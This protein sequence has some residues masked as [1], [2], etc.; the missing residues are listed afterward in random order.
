M[1]QFNRRQVLAAL[2]QVLAAL[3]GSTA[4]PSLA[5]PLAGSDYRALVCVFLYG[6][7]D[8]NNMVVP[9]DTAGYAA[10][11]KARGTAGAGGLTL[12]QSSLAP[13]NGAALGLR[14]HRS[15]AR[16][17]GCTPRSPRWP[18]SGTRGTSRCRPTSARSSDP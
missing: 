3:A 5:A 14:S 13:L 1:H 15:T 7:N 8:G 10:Y 9:M 12:A 11:A 18:T 17:S 6:G 2:P 16:P 4:L